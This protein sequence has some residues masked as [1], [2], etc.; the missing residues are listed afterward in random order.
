M[1]EGCLCFPDVLNVAFS[2]L[3]EVNNKFT[4]A[5]GVVKDGVGFFGLLAGEE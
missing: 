1:V 4:F 5:G 2:A 3:H